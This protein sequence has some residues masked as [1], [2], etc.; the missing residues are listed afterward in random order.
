MKEDH[1]HV[2]VEGQLPVHLKR[3]ATMR[4]AEEKVR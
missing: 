2:A 1:L 4:V 3:L